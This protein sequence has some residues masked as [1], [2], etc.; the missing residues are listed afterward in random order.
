M[1]GRILIQKSFS[2]F[3]GGYH[4]AFFFAK[5]SRCLQIRIAA[6]DC[7]YA[8]SL[9]IKTTELSDAGLMLCCGN[10][11]L[12]ASPCRGAN[13]NFFLRSRLIAKFTQKLQK[14]STADGI[15]IAGVFFCSQIFNAVI[16]N[17]PIPAVLTAPTQFMPKTLMPVSNGRYLHQ[18]R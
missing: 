9:S 15:V 2:Q 17:H 5:P 11:L 12:A 1:R 10:N 4:A 16:K 8:F 14:N 6:D 3:L 18:I 7:V 13:F